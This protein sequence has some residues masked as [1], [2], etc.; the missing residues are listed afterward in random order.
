[1]DL[2]KG[3]ITRLLVSGLTILS[4]VLGAAEVELTS[5]SRTYRRLCVTVDAQISTS[6]WA[7]LSPAT[8]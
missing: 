8:P 1:M 6:L 4:E 2:L 7:T 5:R 3:N